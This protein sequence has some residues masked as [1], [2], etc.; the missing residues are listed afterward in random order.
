[1]TDETS[2][3]FGLPQVLAIVFAGALLLLVGYSLFANKW[4][5]VTVAPVDVGSAP[6]APQEVSEAAQHVMESVES[7]RRA[8]AKARLLE[9][10]QAAD[11][12]N[13][14][15]DELEAEIVSWKT[16]VEAL[17]END[18]GRFLANNPTYVDAFHE[19]YNKGQRPS[20]KTPD[21]LRTVV[22]AAIEP[23]SNALRN[24]EAIYT[25][26]Q[27]LWDHLD[28]LRT[29][30]LEAT[31]SY[32]K[33]ARQIQSMVDASR[34]DPSKAPASR[35]LRET[36]DS[37][38]NRDALEQAEAIAL[39]VEE[40]TRKAN[41]KLAQLEAERVRNEAARE[42]EKKR[43]QEEMKQR[44]ANRE[45]ARTREEEQRKAEQARIDALQRR[46]ADPSVQAKYQPFLAKGTYRFNKLGLTAQ[47][48]PSYAYRYPRPASYTDMQL[49]GVLKNVVVFCKTA[50]G[51][52]KQ[53]QTSILAARSASVDRDGFGGQGYPNDR[54]KWNWY[55][56]SESEWKEAEARYR[57][58]IELAPYWIKTGA[59]VP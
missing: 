38:A 55:P 24:Q 2:R 32:R 59:L 43:L 47:V 35:T 15:I 49:A 34:R 19:I 11:E 28:E 16:E 6:G 52:S 51:Q 1:M 14:A 39:V 31:R 10:S 26:D 58:F 53:H 44:E 4:G 29:Q 9:F 42:L 40:E 33:D 3:R 36:L 27:S 13:E 56:Q 54:P 20:P 41:K 37:M 7:E 21:R 50:A 18:A 5:A 25:P 45:L 23:V 48:E 30:A 46:A 22:A 57:E 17:L 12:V 8:L